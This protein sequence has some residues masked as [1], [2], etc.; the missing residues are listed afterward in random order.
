MVLLCL[1]GTLV[2]FTCVASNSIV[3]RQTFALKSAKSFDLTFTILTDMTNEE[4]K[5]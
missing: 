2:C 1:F 4:K 3:K 5:K